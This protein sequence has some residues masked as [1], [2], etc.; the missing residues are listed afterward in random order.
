MLCRGEG[1]PSPH[2]ALGMSC[3]FMP[4]SI[5]TQRHCHILYSFF[6]AIILTL[7]AFVRAYVCECLHACV[8]VCVCACVLVCVRTFACSQKFVLTVL[9]SL[10]HNGLCTPIWRSS[11]SKGTLLLS[12]LLL[13]YS[14]SG[15][16]QAPGQEVYRHIHLQSAEG[17]DFSAS[18]GKHT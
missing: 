13:L 10:L 3:A 1:L 6:K 16:K 7:H 5:I 8:Q 14:Q 15:H 12:L 4:T 17:C 11:A 2:H 9:C 18:K